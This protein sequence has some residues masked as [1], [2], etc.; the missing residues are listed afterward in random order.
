MRVVFD[1]NIFISALV[2]PGSQAE[3]AVTRVLE[4]VD[5]L[6]LSKAILDEV[7]IT[8][9]RKFSRDPEALSQTAVLLSEMAAV[10]NP[11]RTVSIFK[12][13][14]D[15]RIL[16]C[17]EAGQAECIVTGDKAMLQLKEYQGIRLISL[18]D[19]LISGL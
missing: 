17:A 16:E 18:R 14:P 6:I 8:L 12:D 3:E 15:N 19:Y 1:S 11:T 9:G 5:T 7:L 10:V 4:G 13:D 2:F